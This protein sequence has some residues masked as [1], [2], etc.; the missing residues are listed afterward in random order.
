LQTLPTICGSYFFS[1]R[2][3][4]TKDLGLGNLHHL[5]A[6]YLILSQ[7]EASCLVIEQ[8]NKKAHP[9]DGL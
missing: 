8:E 9:R 5:C 6:Q 1:A 2:F 4:K 3:L 7:A